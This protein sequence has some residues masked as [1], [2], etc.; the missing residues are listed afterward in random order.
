MYN[1]PTAN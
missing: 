1:H